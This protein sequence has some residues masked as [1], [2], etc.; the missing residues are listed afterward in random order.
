MTL[1]PVLILAIAEEPGWPWDKV[2]KDVVAGLANGAGSDL[3]NPHYFAPQTIDR[4]A[5]GEY[6]RVQFGLAPGVTAKVHVLL[7]PSG[8]DGKIAYPI[9]AF[10][11]IQGERHTAVWR[12]SFRGD[13]K[14]GEYDV[15]VKAWPRNPDGSEAA[16]RSGFT[17]V[18]LLQKKKW[19][20]AVYLNGDD[21]KLSWWEEQDLLQIAQAG[22][23]DEVSVIVLHDRY[24]KLRDDPG[25]PPGLAATNDT[26]LYRVQTPPRFFAKFKNGHHLIPYVRPD[27]LKTPGMADKSEDLLYSVN[28]ADM[29]DVRTL[30]E[31]LLY[32]DRYHPAERLYVVLADHGGG[33]GGTQTDST[34]QAGPISL[35]D[36]QAALDALKKQREGKLL[37]VLFFNNCLMAQVEVLAML[38]GIVRYAVASEPISWSGNLPFGRWLQHFHKSN[39][40]GSTEDAAEDV[41]RFIDRNSPTTCA[42]FR[43]TKAE[44]GE[45]D[46][47]DLLAEIKKVVGECAALPPKDHMALIDLRKQ[48][49]NADHNY[50]YPGE[51]I[52]RAGSVTIDL[53]DWMDRLAAST[54]A[55]ENR[56]LDRAI[57]DWNL[58]WETVQLRT[59]VHKVYQG[60]LHGLGIF[61]PAQFLER[62][63]DGRRYLYPNVQQALEDFDN[64]VKRDPGKGQAYEFSVGTVSGDYEAQVDVAGYAGL[65]AWSDWIRKDLVPPR[66]RKI[67]LVGVPMQGGG[68]LDALH[69]DLG[70]YERAEPA[71]PQGRLG[72][73]PLIL[74]VEFN[75]EMDV[76][77]PAEI[78]FD[79]NPD[80]GKH[81]FKP[82]P[83]WDAKKRIWRGQFEIESADEFQGVN[84]LRISAKDAA[85]NVLDSDLETPDAQPDTRFTFVVGL[86]PNLCTIIKPPDGDF[87][88]YRLSGSLTSGTQTKKYDENKILKSKSEL[89]CSVA[90]AADDASLA[91]YFGHVGVLLPTGRGH[92]PPG[93]AQGMPR[94]M[95]VSRDPIFMNTTLSGDVEASKRAYNG[96][97]HFTQCDENGIAGHFSATFHAE[98][99]AKT[100]SGSIPVLVGRLNLMG[101]FRYSKSRYEFK[102][103]N[104][105]MGAMAVGRRTSH[106]VKRMQG[107][108]ESVQKLLEPLRKAAPK[109]LKIPT[110]QELALMSQQMAADEMKALSEALDEAARSGDYAKVN[111]LF[112][113]LRERMEEAAGPA[114]GINRMN[115]PKVK[116]LQKELEEAGKRGDFAKMME[117]T[118][119]MQKII[120]GAESDIKRLSDTYLKRA[121]DALNSLKVPFSVVP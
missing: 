91:L 38:H 20:V 100:E 118:Q 5:E 111:S 103:W 84:R 56:H 63:I 65:G 51:K 120:S 22:S 102:S 41:V 4:V 105:L 60:K 106:E 85:G 68:A 67:R 12:V 28:E 1:L 44:P 2:V 21:P 54:M 23:T 58:V 15:E 53:K 49:I 76:A 89:K 40:K 87:Y 46:I 39:V 79:A 16:P 11:S 80:Y 37:D 95:V 10:A 121:R 94:L 117:L 97:I 3:E 18:T 98:A 36:L 47:R 70:K 96:E 17:R 86:P 71:P 55:K 48:T 82:E 81:K 109:D 110:E 66:V 33:W 26:R 93:M 6:L 50:D 114:A 112:S 61:Y 31:F 113:E 13:M 34:S 8:G 29:G 108:I 43:V 45:W 35:K 64:K 101:C 19:T 59:Y 9:E 116:T 27:L 119:R 42:A 73:G 107:E 75:E 62:D 104:A 32:C 25:D 24:Q 74:E 52:L 78:T 77:S 69:Q 14:P 99:Y 115:D 83:G 92:A 7:R 30:R 90:M 88:A 57:K 72:P